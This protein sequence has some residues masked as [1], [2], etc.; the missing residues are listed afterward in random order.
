MSD[1]QQTE[2][3]EPTGEA[4]EDDV[5]ELDDHRLP[6]YVLDRVDRLI[7]A[8]VWDELGWTADE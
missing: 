4:T 2:A 5:R 6:S 7:P 3:T 8:T 1:A